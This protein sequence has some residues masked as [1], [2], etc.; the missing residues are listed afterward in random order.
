MYVTT[1]SSFLLNLAVAALDQNFMQ[2]RLWSI[3]TKVRVH[4]NFVGTRRIK[5]KISR[6][7]CRKCGVVL[8]LLFSFSFFKSNL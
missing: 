7:S 8:L 3:H 5:V 4:F 1:M 2:V 6:K